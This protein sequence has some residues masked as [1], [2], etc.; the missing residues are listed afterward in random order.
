MLL[1]GGETDQCT[2]QIAMGI[3]GRVS[4]TGWVCCRKG[5]GARGRD[6][7]GAFW[8][9]G[10]WVACESVVTQEWEVELGLSICALNIDT[11]INIPPHSPPTINIQLFIDTFLT[12][13]HSDT[14]SQSGNGKWQ[15]TYSR[16][17][18]QNSCQ[19]IRKY[20]H[21][22]SWACGHTRLDAHK[23]W[24][25]RHWHNYLHSNLKQ[26]RKNLPCQPHNV[27]C[28]A[29]CFVKRNDHSMQARNSSWTQQQTLLLS[30]VYHKAMAKHL[31]FAKPNYKRHQCGIIPTI[32][33]EVLHSH[34]LPH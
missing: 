16:S 14:L 22:M 5:M 24:G 6:G 28:A 34:P 21:G 17:K 19:D 11:C 4:C 20:S 1:W 18:A 25:C 33:M 8:G 12:R 2:A 26:H 9:W 13:I 27:I 15:L 3:E 7:W 31:K 29:R 23:G 32:L 30:I 10:Q